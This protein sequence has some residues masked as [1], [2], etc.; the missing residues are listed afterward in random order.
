MAQVHKQVSSSCTS[1]PQVH[2]NITDVCSLACRPVP[3]PVKECLT[4]TKHHSSVG[5][6]LHQARHPTATSCH[7]AD[8]AQ[9]IHNRC[10]GLTPPPLHTSMHPQIKGAGQRRQPKPT[11]QGGSSTYSKRQ[12]TCS[13]GNSVDRATSKPVMCAPCFYRHMGLHLPFFTGPLKQGCLSNEVWAVER[14]G[15]S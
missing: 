6:V 1:M 4:A 7:D 5:C 11:N 2:G 14:C 12:D 9:A 13:S 10:N 15:R 8:A 3:T